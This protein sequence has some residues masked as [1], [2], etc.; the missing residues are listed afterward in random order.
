V[1]EYTVAA[2]K[3][4]RLVLPA[5]YRPGRR[6]DQHLQRVPEK[7]VHAVGTN[8]WASMCGKP[9]E[10]LHRFEHVNRHLRCPMCDATAGHP[11]RR[12]P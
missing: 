8:T 3:V 2:D 1:W 7:L 12:R 6:V 5:S 10:G 4:S 9:V 11:R